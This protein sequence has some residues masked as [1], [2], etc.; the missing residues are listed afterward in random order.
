MNPLWSAIKSTLT[1]PGGIMVVSANS[2]LA[3]LRLGPHVTVFAT[4]VSKRITVM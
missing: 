3:A 1:K 4:L 2:K